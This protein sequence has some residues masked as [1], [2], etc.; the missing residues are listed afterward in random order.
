MYVGSQENYPQIYQVIYLSHQKVFYSQCLSK[1]TNMFTDLFNSL[2]LHPFP[3]GF[4]FLSVIVS[5]K[6]SEW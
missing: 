3:S 4:S 1:F 6:V 5:V 2:L